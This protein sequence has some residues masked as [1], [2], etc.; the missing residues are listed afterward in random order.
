MSFVDMRTIQRR[1]AAKDARM[2]RPA[3]KAAPPKQ[4]TLK[5]VVVR[6]ATQDAER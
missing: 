3:P 4:P 1:M 5:P 2:K 6:K